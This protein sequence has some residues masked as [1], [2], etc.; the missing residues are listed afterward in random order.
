MTQV[1]KYLTW[2]QTEYPIQWD[3]AR[4]PQGILYTWEEVF[5]LIEVLEG[6]KSGGHKDYHDAYKHL[7][8]EKKEVIIK[9]IAR[10]KGEDFKEEKARQKGIKVTAED[11]ELVLQEVLHIQVNKIG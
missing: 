2:E 11:I 5:V 1:K 10:V 6:V 3:D 7:K 8:P 4:N 9:L